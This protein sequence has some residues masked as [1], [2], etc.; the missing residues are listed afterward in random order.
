VD[1]SVWLAIVLASIAPVHVTRGPVVT[2]V[3]QT[4]AHIAFLTDRP[5]TASVRI[6]S[7]DV[8]GPVTSDHR[9]V[10]TGLKP[11]T[12][13]PYELLAGNHQV[14]SGSFRTDPGP[15]GSFRAAVFGDYGEGTTAEHGV[16]KLTAGW[17]PDVFVSTGDNVYLFAAG[18]A[19]LDPNMF[20]PLEPL[21]E[22]AAF[23]PALGNHD[24]YFDG[25]RTLL[26]ALDLPSPGH[27]FVQRYGPIAF[28]VLDSDANLAPGSP[29]VAF[30]TQALRQTQDAC[31]RVTVW[32]H[33]PFN[34]H[35]GGIAAALA[36]TVVPRIQAGKVQ[37]ALLGHVHDYERSYV[38]KG[39]TYAVVGTGGAVIGRYPL[40]SIPLASHL[41]NTFGAL[42]LDVSPQ[43]IRATFEDV[44]GKVRDRFGV[45]C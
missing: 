37:L 30:L 32:H 27:W 43:R 8:A 28:I 31:F 13:Y 11:G 1:V 35:S 20:G 34:P 29:Q 21:L 22:Q 16:V 12:R 9:I 18:G 14:G 24:T 33:P 2:Q 26:N 38:R 41:I 17:H 4:G 39:V 3:G 6:D 7:R 19:L 15:N 23:V 44:T 42:R 36:R 10:V 25:G 45:T 40:S 5:V